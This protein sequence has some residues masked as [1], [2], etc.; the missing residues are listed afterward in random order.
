MKLLDEEDQRW[1]CFKDDELYCAKEHGWTRKVEEA[2]PQTIV[3]HKE[4]TIGGKAVRL[5]SIFV[6]AL[7]GAIVC[8]ALGFPPQIVVPIIGSLTIVPI[9]Q[10]VSKRQRNA[11]SQGQI[12]ATSPA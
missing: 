5:L 3:E 12:S 7:G 1:Y 11:P 2:F 8:V 10:L 4:L 9:S 6:A